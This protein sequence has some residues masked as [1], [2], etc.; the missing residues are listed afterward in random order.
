M[1]R[2]TIGVSTKVNLFSLKLKVCIWVVFMRSSR[3]RIDSVLRCTN[4]NLVSENSLRRN[5]AKTDFTFGTVVNVT[6]IDVSLSD[7]LPSLYDGKAKELGSDRV[8]VQ[9]KVQGN[10]DKIDH[11][12][13][14]LETLGIRTIV[15]KSHNITNSNYFQFVDELTNEE[16][17][18]LTY[19]IM[20]V[21][22]D[23][24]RGTELK[25]NQV[26]I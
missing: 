14:I 18:G 23:Y 2:E 13:V 12:I 17:G 5:H 7:V 21:Y 9:W 15:G 1:G 19:Y 4:G 26:V 11:F 3:A 20:P 16:S 25:T 10:V 22:Y 24:S 6:D 8:L